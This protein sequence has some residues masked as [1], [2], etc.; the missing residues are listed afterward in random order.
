MFLRWPF[1]LAMLAWSVLVS[2]APRVILVSWD[3]AGYEMTSKLLAEGRL[4]NLQRML[5][6]GA[7]S[8]GM[9]SSFPTK[10]A[11]AHAVL[12]TGHYGH[13]SGITA[14]ALLLLPASEHNRLETESG[15]FSN[16]LRVD[17][18]WIL[19][20]KNGLDTYAMHATQA[21]P[22]DDARARLSPSELEHLFL[23]HGYTE[24][25]FAR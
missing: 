19:A 23:I 6:E 2:A 3:G 13:R 24:V 9:V 4:P 10:T 5:R 15:Y 11:A 8:D 18:V 25:Q 1:V 14:N 20:A 21:Y 7:W 17:P 16:A 22:F 12:F